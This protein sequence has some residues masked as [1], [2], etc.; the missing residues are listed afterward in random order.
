MT[1]EQLRQEIE[2]TLA[3][4]PS[5]QFVARVRQGLTADAQRSSTFWKPMSI[6]LS[7]AVII[8]MVSLDKSPVAPQPTSM[9]TVATITPPSNIVITKPKLQSVTK[10]KETVR[11]S[12]GPE[13][14]I[15]TR[16]A[17]AFRNLVEDL[18]EQRIDPAKLEALFEA[19]E[20]NRT[21]KT[22]VPVPV[23]GL[24]PIVIPPVTPEV[25]EKEG[26]SL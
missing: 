24:E 9:P 4:E 11:R 17:K 1:E 21:M 7:A 25:A 18:Q 26:G 20:R 15:D 16:E 8:A 13:V 6:A 5:A 10:P 23:A 19:A 2:Q 12:P 14:L 22:I 3:A